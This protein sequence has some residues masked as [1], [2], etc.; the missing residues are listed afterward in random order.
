MRPAHWLKQMVALR[1]P[2]QIVVLDT[3]THCSPDSTNEIMHHELTLGYA[4]CYRLE[5]GIRTRLKECHF[6]TVDAF[7]DWL[8]TVVSPERSTHVFGHNLGYDLGIL[9]AWYRFRDDR[10]GFYRVAV[11]RNIVYI[12]SKL[13][14]SHVVFVD[15]ANYWKCSLAQIAESLGREKTPLPDT[16]IVSDE[17]WERCRTDVDITAEAVDRL[18]AWIVDGKY[19]PFGVSAASL[20]MNTYKKRFMA[21]K[22]LVHDNEDVLTLERNSYFGG[23]VD[24][25]FIGKPDVS[26]VYECDVVSMYPAICLGNL[27]TKLVNWEYLSSV[28]GL[29]KL[30][31]KYM[32]IAD[33]NI[34]TDKAIY[35]VRY[36]HQ[37]VYPIGSF[38]TALAHAELAVALERGHIESCNFVAY[39]EYA[40]IFKEFMEH[41]L[42]QKA[43]WRHKKNDMNETIVKLMLNSLY[44]KTGQLSPCWF[45]IND[46]NIEYAER[47]Y[48]LPSGTLQFLIK[49]PP[50]IERYEKELRLPKFNLTIKMRQL[51]R[52]VEIQIGEQETRDSCPSIAAC[53]TSAA[54]V[55]L[56]EMQDACVYNGH[57]YSDTDSIW[58]SKDDLAE[59]TRRGFIGNS[60]GMLQVKGICESLTI[61]GKKDYVA[62]GYHKYDSFCSLETGIDV[63]KRKGIRAKAIEQSDGSFNQEKWAQP[64][65]QIKSGERGR[66]TVE[67]VN[68]TLHREIKHCHVSEDGSTTPLLGEELQ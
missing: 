10:W 61:H 26:P 15:T 36:N 28:D 53:V 67:I 51:W 63:V 48:A 3:E 8:E 58:C 1:C 38:T 34:K 13:H 19:G 44:G 57:L 40:P 47:F 18:I 12:D 31:T 35:P 6:T 29:K 64:I 66:V 33:V 30:A 62:S 25:P 43:H 52:E 9:D 37:T 39:Y 54:R 60:V 49:H 17:L 20:S 11:E 59:L 5:R 42:E 23:F 22:I 65:S 41:F 7:W 46:D 24:T 45:V 32:L 2:S 56:R 4:I 21:H 68:K 27:P 50:I 14:D 16:T 55:K